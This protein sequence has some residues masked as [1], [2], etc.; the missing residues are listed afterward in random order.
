MRRSAVATW[1]SP[2][3]RRHPRAGNPLP[4][5]VEARFYE[6]TCQ[7][8]LTLNLVDPNHIVI[9]EDVF[10]TLLEQSA[11][12]ASRFDLDAER[13]AALEAHGIFCDGDGKSAFFPIVFQTLRRR[14]RL[15]NRPAAWRIARRRCPNA[16][17]RIAARTASAPQGH[18]SALIADRGRPAWCATR[19]A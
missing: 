5:V 9:S 2:S 7:I 6:V 12:L 18:A 4:P 1:Q 19:I 13:L 3:L 8:A 11:E 15:R 16:T 17:F 14:P 10:W